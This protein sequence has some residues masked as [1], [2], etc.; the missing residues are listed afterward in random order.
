VT[1]AEIDGVLKSYA[2]AQEIRCFLVLVAC[3]SVAARV[4]RCFPLTSN[5][6]SGLL[7][8]RVRCPSPAT[9]RVAGTWVPFP[10]SKA[11][12]AAHGGRASLS[13]GPIPGG[14]RDSHRCS[15]STAATGR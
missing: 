11:T 8:E 9:R 5:G 3:G 6:P 12:L 15:S 13:A 10:P 4:T 1:L 14:E 2:R 7:N